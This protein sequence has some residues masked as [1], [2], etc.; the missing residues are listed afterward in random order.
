MIAVQEV[1]RDLGELDKLCTL[2]GPWWRFLVSDVTEG[3]PGNQERLAYVF[4]IRKVRHSGLAGKFALPARADADGEMRAP[5]Q[6]ARTP[7]AFG[8]KTA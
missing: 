6:I 5:R 3:H 4:D 2:L 8:L 7:F 1:K